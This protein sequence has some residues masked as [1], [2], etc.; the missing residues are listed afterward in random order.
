MDTLRWLDEENCI[1]LIDQTLLPGK[2]KYIKAKSIEAVAK[3]IEILQVRGA[4]AI[5]VMAAMGVALGAT[6]FRGKDKEKFYEYMETVF[7]RIERTRPTAVNLFWALERQRGIIAK[8]AGKDVAGITA[9][10]IEEGKKMRVED[11]KIN[12]RMGANGAKLLKKGSRV[13]THCNAGSL[14]TADYGTA[15]G[16]IRAAYAKGRIE[17]VYADETRPRLQGAMLTAFEMVQEGI[18]CS[19]NCDNAAATLMARGMI[20]AVIV[21][22]DRIAANGDT[23]NKIGTY[24]LAIVSKAHKVPF[25]VAAPISTIDYSLKSGAEIPIEERDGDEVRKI[26]REVI[27]PDGVDI[28]NYA[29]D[30]T[31]AKLIAGIIT[32]NG[33]AAPPNRKNLAKLR[34]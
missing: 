23:A 30:V 16:V 5:G 22:A 33:V 25:Y 8:N 10:L 14:A 20:D 6:K 4:P 34:K 18:P 26:G 13:M 12:K 11:I 7:E 17:R 3:A 28:V 32:E 29:F 2:F 19:L 24:S 15:L 21:G 9:A 27:C 31:P 1:E